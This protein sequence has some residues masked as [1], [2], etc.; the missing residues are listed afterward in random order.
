MDKYGLSF[1]QGGTHMAADQSLSAWGQIRDHYFLQGHVDHMLA[2]RHP[3]YEDIHAAHATQ[4]HR[5][6]GFLDENDA[7]RARAMAASL[8]ILMLEKKKAAEMLY[9]CVDGKKY[10]DKE[11]VN[12]TAIAALESQV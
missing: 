7:L 8:F 1:G 11:F 5:S 12:H 10:P 3:L 6:A 4:S 2:L 9:P